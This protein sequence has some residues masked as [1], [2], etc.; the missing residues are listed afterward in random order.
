[1][2]AI[3]CLCLLLAACSP[4]SAE[5]DTP[6]VDLAVSDVVYSPT[7]SEGPWQTSKFWEL[8]AQPQHLWIRSD[9]QLEPHHVP[10]GAPLGVG[11]SGM[12]S[13]EVR[14]DGQRLASRGRPAVQPEDEVPGPISQVLHVP[15]H[16]AT[17]GAHRLD[18]RCS[19]YHRGFTPSFGYWRLK[20]GHY[21]RLLEG[22]RAVSWSALTTLSGML[23]VGVYYL[24]LFVLDRRRRPYLLLAALALAAAGLLVAEA[25]RNVL[26]Y[27]YDWHIVRLRCVAWL[28]WGVGC[29]L[30]LFLSDQ[31]NVGKNWRVRLAALLTISASL[32]VFPSWD[33]K[34]VGSL[35]TALIWALLICL[36]AW[37]RRRDGSPAAAF[38]VGFCLAI[39]LWDLWSFVDRNLYLGLGLLL[40]LLMASHA[41]HVRAE[42]RQAEATRLRSSRL[43]VE[44]LRRHLQP[45]FL[46][47]TLTA[48]SEWVEEEPQVAVRMI[49]ALADEMRLLGDISQRH[50]IPLADE[51]ELCRH[52]LDVMGM[53]HDR[54]YRLASQVVDDQ[55]AVPPA[56]F[57][58]LVENA[59]THGASTDGDTTE[60]RLVQQR[61]GEGWK[62][63]GW[64]YTFESPLDP[65]GVDPPESRAEG[66]GLQYVKA[67][68]NERYG[69]AWRFE[70]GRAGD[71]WRSVLQVPDSAPA[72]ATP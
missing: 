53:R 66:T 48:L 35:L 4:P 46:M 69:D 30:L 23:V 13:C 19:H 58:T 49:E 29:L 61:D 52:H 17:T 51:L 6:S 42:Q 10:K 32:V 28:A 57:H 24:V 12:A 1:M 5:D 43:E 65:S 70:H 41:R 59:V 21:G 40:I 36:A 20:V 9:V 27:T 37:R 60:L 11:V 50:Q 44:L 72:E 26:G 67:R 2:W 38:G 54:R 55:A 64:K 3:S 62:G 47:N 31:F 7:S 68:L 34:I 63:D 71:V 14:W 22:E 8:P 25:W 39:L 16:L 56:I 45:H 33:G 15:D 18:L